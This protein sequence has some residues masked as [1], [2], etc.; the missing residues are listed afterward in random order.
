LINKH[1]LIYFL[2]LVHETGK[3]LEGRRFIF[4]LVLWIR[5]GYNSDS[6][7]DPDPAFFVNADPNMDRFRSRVL[8]NKNW[9]IFTAEKQLIFI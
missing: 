4:F 1:F 7:T 6:D 8:M 9:K 5:I 3:N 2:L